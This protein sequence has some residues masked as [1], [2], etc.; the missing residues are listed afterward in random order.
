MDLTLRDIAAFLKAELVGD[1]RTVIRGAAPFETAS[2]DQITFAGG[3]RFKKNRSD[4]RRCHF[5]APGL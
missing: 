2:G 3:S 5:S 4:G 1:G